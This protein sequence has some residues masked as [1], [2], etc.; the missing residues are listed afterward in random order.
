MISEITD[1]RAFFKAISSL[2]QWFISFFLI[3]Q[4]RINLHF[5]TGKGSVYLKNENGE[6]TTLQKELKELKSRER[7]LTNALLKVIGTKRPLAKSKGVYAPA[8]LMLRNK[9][10]W[11]GAKCTVNYS[12][13]FVH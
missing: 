7:E 8:N 5:I 3:C 12:P 9:C 10:L 11:F 2:N 1:F 6:L 4:S 13:R